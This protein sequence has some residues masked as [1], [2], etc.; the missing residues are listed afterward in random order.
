MPEIPKP[1]LLH[2]V[3]AY[4]PHAADTRHASAG[5]VNMVWPYPL[6][7]H[8]QHH[9]GHDTAARTHQLYRAI[10][11]SHSIAC[12]L[13]LHDDFISVIS[14]YLPALH[15]PSTREIAFT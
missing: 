3:R 2:K 15:H 13:S 10:E 1:P 6:A 5:G 14:Y 12:Q 11:L 9:F 4:M 7:K 8:G